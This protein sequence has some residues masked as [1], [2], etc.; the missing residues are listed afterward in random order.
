MANADSRQRG[1]SFICGGFYGIGIG[2]WIG[3]LVAVVL[4]VKSNWNP[5]YLI[6]V[7]GIQVIIIGIARAIRGP[8]PAKK[9]QTEND[10][11]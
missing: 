3:A 2:F 10:T 1:R 7:M 4:D 9:R 5:L 8:A 11:A 6:A